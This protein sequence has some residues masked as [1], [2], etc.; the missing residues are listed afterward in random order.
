[1]PLSRNLQPI[2]DLEKSLGNEMDY[3]VSNEKCGMY[4]AFVRP[5][6]R[7]AI[8]KRLVLSPA[9]TWQQFRDP[10]YPL[11][12]GYVCSETN[13]TVVGPLGERRE[14]WLSE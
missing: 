8:E 7:A 6:H 3:Y 13:H 2:F 14:S 10:H 5:L 4:I 1:M 11:E 9:L 12:E